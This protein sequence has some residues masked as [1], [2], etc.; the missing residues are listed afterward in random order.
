MNFPVVP[1][2]NKVII[3]RDESKDT[4]GRIIMPDVAKEKCQH[5][6]VMSVGQ[7][8]L[9]DDGTWAPIPVKAGDRV[10]FDK[11]MGS[12]LEHDRQKYLIVGAVDLLARLDD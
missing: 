11:Y 9:R 10:L 1:L 3:R 5:G 4:I 12:D 8:K 7:G 2:G 6:V